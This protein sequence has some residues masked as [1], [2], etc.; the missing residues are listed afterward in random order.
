MLRVFIPSLTTIKR[1]ENV[2]LSSKK[3]DMR[4][5]TKHTRQHTVEMGH[6]KVVGRKNHTKLGNREVML[7]RL[8]WLLVEK[9][10][11][12]KVIQFR[13]TDSDKGYWAFTMIKLLN[14]WRIF[15]NNQDPRKHQWLMCHQAYTCFYWKE[16]ICYNFPQVWTG[17]LVQSHTHLWNGETCN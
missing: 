15:K 10:S 3:G 12:G 9:I 7:I 13:K 5:F 6:Q 16:G 14:R 2:S 4:S 17:V 1:L 8:G 11:Q